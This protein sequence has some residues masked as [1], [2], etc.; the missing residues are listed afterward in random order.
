LKSPSNASP[1][2][3]SSASRQTRWLPTLELDIWARAVYGKAVTCQPNPSICALGATCRAF[4]KMRPPLTDVLTSGLKDAP[5]DALND[6]ADKASSQRRQ[7]LGD[8][9]DAAS[10][11]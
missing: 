7:T 4:P 1:M 8:V 5:N 3:L 6:T 11:R 9:P 2:V 10:T